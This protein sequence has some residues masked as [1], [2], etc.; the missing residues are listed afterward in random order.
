[1]TSLGNASAG[2]TGGGDRTPC[3]SSARL[4]D[5]GVV[6]ARL[7]GVSYRHVFRL[8]DGGLMPWG[9]KLGGRRLWNLAE[10]DGWISNGCKPVRT[11]RGPSHE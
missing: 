5:V 9:I 8:A 11:A 7:G 2:A 3:E 6:S 1:M 4:G 10:L